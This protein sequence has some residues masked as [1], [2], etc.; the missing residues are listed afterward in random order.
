M[1]WGTPLKEERGTPLK[2]EKEAVSEHQREAYH[3][4][5]HQLAPFLRP[6]FDND[7]VPLQQLGHLHLIPSHLLFL[8]TGYIGVS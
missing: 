1:F 2:E 7:I 5:I 4:G 8:H 6:T 3:K